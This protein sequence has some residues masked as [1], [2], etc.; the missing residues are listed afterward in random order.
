MNLL[1]R[2]VQRLRRPSVVRGWAVF[3]PQ[4]EVI[5]HSF[6]GS[7]EGA[8]AAYFRTHYTPKLDAVWQPAARAGYAVR[9]IHWKRGW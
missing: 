5:W 1:Q 7:R 8:I 4:D 3:S 9:K 2:L 6:A